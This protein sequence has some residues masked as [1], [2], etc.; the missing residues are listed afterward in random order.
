[1]HRY[2]SRA[3]W[4]KIVQLMVVFFVLRTQPRGAGAQSVVNGAANTVVAQETDNFI[5]GHQEFSRYTTPGLCL[6]AARTTRAMLRQNLAVQQILDTLQNSM[7]D[8][9]GVRGATVVARAC[10]TRFT[11]TSVAPQDL[12]DLFQIALF[13][14]NDT[15]AQAVLVRAAAGLPTV[16]ARVNLYTGALQ[17]ILGGGQISLDRPVVQAVRNYIGQNGGGAVRLQTHDQVLRY[18]ETHD[19]VPSITRAAEELLA[20]A[21]HIPATALVPDSSVSGAEP[22]YHAYRDLMKIAFFQA[23]D[24]MPSIAQ[25]AKQ[26]LGWYRTY[27]T[28]RTKIGKWQVYQNIDFRSLSVD[29]IISLLYPYRDA[30]QPGRPRMAPLRAD[31]WFPRADSVQPARGKVTLF[32]MGSSRHV[33]TQ[34]R[35]LIAQYGPSGLNVV[36]VHATQG[37]RDYGWYEAA[38]GGPWKASQEADELQWYDREY[39]QLPV[40]VAVQA[41]HFTARS[42]PDERLDQLDTADF[43]HGQCKGRLSNEDV[44]CTVLV[45]REGT[46]LYQGYGLLAR[47]RSGEW[48]D[49]IFADVVA[50]AM[51]QLRSNTPS[52]SA[53]A[54]EPRSVGASPRPT[55]LSKSESL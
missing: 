33:A 43:I 11:V 28:E 21:R 20:G 44:G 4:N 8:T 29:S 36:L 45:G 31:F 30:W 47:D 37:W 9:L 53:S 34:V 22:I 41:Q 18:W 14:Q 40:T 52:A 16:A 2:S 15:L 7:W 5:P 19:D 3:M 27:Y 25:R 24:S 39:E 6:V 50:K 35:K 10:A 48:Y 13:T 26:D 49:N 17:A 12:S 42:A 51:A 23:P 46:I 32:V 55:S 54:V 1:M 38:L